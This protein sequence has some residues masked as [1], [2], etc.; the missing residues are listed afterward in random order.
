[1]LEAPCCANACRIADSKHSCHTHLLQMLAGLP[2]SETLWPHV[3][4]LLARLQIPDIPAAHIW[5][6]CWQGCQLLKPL[7]NMC[8]NCWQGCSFQT[9]LPRTS[10]ANA[11]RVANS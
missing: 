9:F 7:G 1:M 4:Q 8:C 11:G 10:A 3:L 2:T 5:F 6:K